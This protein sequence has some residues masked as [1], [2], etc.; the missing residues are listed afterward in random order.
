MVTGQEKTLY[1]FYETSVFTEDLNDFLGEDGLELLFAIQSDLVA[2]PERWPIIKGLGGARKGRIAD[3]ASDKGKSG[4]YRYIYLYL[5]HRGQIFLLFLFAKSDQANLDVAQ[6][7]RL[8]K[9]VEQ[10]KKDRK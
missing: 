4:S 1:T 7:K 3:P 5:E 2:D 9:I 8:A 6:T 10:I